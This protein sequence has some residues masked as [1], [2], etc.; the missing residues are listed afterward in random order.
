MPLIRSIDVL[1]DGFR[2]VTTRGGTHTFTSADIP[3]AL[4]NKPLAQIEAAINTAI[5]NKLSPLGMFGAAHL[6]SAVPLN[7]EVT[8]ANEPINPGDVWWVG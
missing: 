6:T 8:V 3:P 1:D 5:A 7:G 2:I 4:L